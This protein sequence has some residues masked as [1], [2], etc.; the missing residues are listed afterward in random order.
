MNRIKIEPLAF[1]ID[2]GCLLIFITKEGEEERYKFD[3][4][5]SIKLLNFLSQ[6][7]DEFNAAVKS[8][9]PPFRSSE[10]YN[11]QLE[12]KFNEMPD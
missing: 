5:Q 2:N 8:S 9:E 3:P 10:W 4:E 1:H 12:Q 6:Y 7:Q 11:E